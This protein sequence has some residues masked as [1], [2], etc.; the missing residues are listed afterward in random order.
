MKTNSNAEE[1]ERDRALARLMRDALAPGDLSACADCPE[2]EVLAAYAD[3]GLTSVQVEHWEQHFASCR[4]CQKMLALLAASAEEPV[5]QGLPDTAVAEPV[6]PVARPKPAIPWFWRWT[7][8]ALVPAVGAVAA[9]MIWFVLRP[10][11][12]NVPS[13]AENRV[14]PTAPLSDQTAIPRVPPPQPPRLEDSRAPADVA[15]SRQPEP[16][17]DSL[18]AKQGERQED[19]ATLAPPAAPTQPPSAI[20]D[21]AAANEPSGGKE[22]LSAQAGQAQATTDTFSTAKALPAEREAKMKT[23]SS[24]QARKPAVPGASN[25]VAGLSAA[26]TQPATFGPNDRSVLWRAGT[27]GHIEHSTDQ[28]RTWQAQTSNV[29]TDLLAGAAVSREAAWVVGRAGV[30]LRT[31]DGASWQRVAPPNGLALDWTSVGTTDALHVTIVSA[32]QR[33]FATAD[34]GRTWQAQ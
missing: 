10:T 15:P 9:A 1:A 18:R 12:P 19:V 20:L 11:T 31:T 33:R 8:L 6:R 14:A 21:S 23:S 13:I 34:G 25:R 3:R 28:G 26:P 4:R 30:I 2:T 27:G 7:R 29:S 22:T 32:D 17:R 5:G 16:A 24:E